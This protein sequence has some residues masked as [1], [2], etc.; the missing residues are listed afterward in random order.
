MTTQFNPLNQNQTLLSQTL[1]TQINTPEP[2]L[3]TF[4]VILKALG[5][6]GGR[7]KEVMFSLANT[8]QRLGNVREAIKQYKKILGLPKAFFKK[9]AAGEIGQWRARGSVRVEVSR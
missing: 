2:K 5:D 6:D 4:T 1:I 9:V 7:M 3:N 8:I